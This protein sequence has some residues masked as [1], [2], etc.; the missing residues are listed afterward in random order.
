MATRTKLI[1][2]PNKLKIKFGYSLSIV[3]TYED[4][5]NLINALQFAEVYDDADYNCTKITPFKAT[6]LDISLLSDNEYK[7]FKAN[8]LLVKDEE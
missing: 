2:P 5:V 8:T 1:N 6:S 7:E 4:G 3:L